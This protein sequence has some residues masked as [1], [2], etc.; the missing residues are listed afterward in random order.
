MD[1]LSYLLSSDLRKLFIT[2]DLEARGV[3]PLFPAL[4]S[5]EITGK[6]V[7]ERIRGK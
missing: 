3:E 1:M 5:S 2:N 7:S 6:A 4:T